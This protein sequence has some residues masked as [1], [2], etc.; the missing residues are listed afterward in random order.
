[1]DAE[2]APRAQYRE[3][4]ETLIH[5]C[6]LHHRVVEKRIEGL[7]VH[8]SQHR[9][10]MKLSR[11]GTTASQKN[12]A[13]AMDVSPACVA[14][15]LKS[16]DAAGLIDR[17]GGTDG[18]CNAVSIR[19]QGQQLVD[20]SLNV[21]RGIDEGMF[22]GFAPEEL[23]TLKSLLGRVQDNLAGMEQSAARQTGAMKGEDS[24]P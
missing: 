17:Q 24:T 8:H 9:M 4:V 22:E 12:I 6:R 2:S 11:M 15:T 7:G 18:R 1:M 13:A 21:F 3:T 16:L 20:A 14:R 10:L 5:T 19:P 23:A